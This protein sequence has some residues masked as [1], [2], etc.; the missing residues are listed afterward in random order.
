MTEEREESYVVAKQPCPTCQAAGGDRSGDNLAVYSDGHTHCFACN[1]HTNGEGRAAPA[2]GTLPSLKRFSSLIEDAEYRPLIKRKITEDTCRHF[3]YRIGKLDGKTV[4][5]A[6]HVVDGKVVAQKIRG[7]GKDFR[8]L[9][10]AKKMTLWGQHLCRDGGKKIV[11]TEGEIDCMSV[12]QVQNNKWPVVSVPNGASGAAKAIAAQIEWLE[13]YEQ[14]IFMFDMDD[15]GQEA[16]RDCALLLSPGRAFIAS[17]PLKDANDML[18]EGRGK[19]LVDAIWGAKE[20]RPDGLVGIEDILDDIDKPVEW[21]LPWVFESLTKFTYGRRPGDVI[22]LG[23][24]TGVGKTDVLTQQIEFDVNTLGKKVGAIFLEQRPSETAIRVAGKAAGKRFHVPD[25]D[26]TREERTAEVQRLQGKLTLYDSFGSTEWPVVRAK[27]RYLAVSGH[28]IVYLDHLTAL[29][30]PSN[31][32]ESL[33]TIMAELAGLAQA[34]GLIIIFVSHLTTPE[35]KPHEEGG[36]VTIRHF[37]GA[38]AI[39]FWSYY[40]FGL[41]RNQQATDPEER[42][43]TTFRCLK[44]RYTG[45]STGKTFGLSYDESTGLLFE[46]PIPEKQTASRFPSSGD[47]GEF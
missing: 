6:P 15:P 37:K 30:D 28:E 27:I 44:D 1:H 17:L 31:E 46:C 39:G 21:G 36:R 42:K 32:R 25:A 23:A 26:W 13:K 33:E 47:D 40:M 12:S 5:V 11:V 2:E 18:V 7:S 24:G 34:L 22:G 3:G 8:V 14:V 4:Q 16:A 35:G 45:Q 19:E 29:A 43:L 10:D 41:E 9:G 38:R 20:Y